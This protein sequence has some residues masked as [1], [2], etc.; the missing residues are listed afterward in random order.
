MT[1]TILQLV[2]A[3]MD[4]YE[5]TGENRWARL[6]LGLLELRTITRQRGTAI[7]CWFA[8]LADLSR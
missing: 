3:A 7:N 2:A 1:D 8:A 5:V 6:A 4:R